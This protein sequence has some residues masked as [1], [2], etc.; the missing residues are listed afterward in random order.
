MRLLGEIG[1][2]QNILAYAFNLRR[3]DGSVNSDIGLA[4]ALNG[5]IYK[6]LSLRP[7][8]DIYGRDLI[9]S[10]TDFNKAAY[11]SAFMENFM[12][13]LGVNKEAEV[14]TVLRSV[15]MNPWVTETSEGSFI[16]ILEREFRRAVLAAVQEVEAPRWRGY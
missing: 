8:S 10:T 13:R 11:G 4:N 9:V 7:G 15:V 1:P 6:H 16:D 2:D 14:V 3:P 12:K 5:A